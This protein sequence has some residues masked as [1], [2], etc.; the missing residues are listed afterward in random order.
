M[1]F[2][3]FLPVPWGIT[4]GTVFSFHLF[5]KYLLSAYHTWQSVRL[6][7]TE[8]NMRNSF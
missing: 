6:G 4:G 5:V 1:P 2:L 3:Q 7:N 8:I